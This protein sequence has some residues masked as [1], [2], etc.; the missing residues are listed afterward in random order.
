MDHLKYEIVRYLTNHS[1]MAQVEIWPNRIFVVDEFKNKKH[2]CL[3][4]DPS[5]QCVPHSVTLSEIALDRIDRS[6]SPLMMCCHGDPWC[7]VA[8]VMHDRKGND[9]RG[10]TDAFLAGAV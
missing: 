9:R 10:G 5:C 7:G 1:I 8:S 3:N 6:H 2:V 4:L